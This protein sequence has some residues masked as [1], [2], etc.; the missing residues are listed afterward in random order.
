MLGGV[1]DSSPTQRLPVLPREAI[2][3]LGASRIRE[4]ANAAMGRADV[5]PF[6]FGESDVP[7]AG[8]IRTAGAESLAAGET[9]YTHNLGLPELRAAIAA[10][11]SR[12]HN[13]VLTPDRVAVVSSGISGL[14]LTAQMLLAPGDR[15]VIVTPIWPNVT[16][17]PRILGAEVIRVPLAVRG[18]R[19]ALDLDHLLAALTPGTRAIFL[20]SPNNPTGWTIDA[21]SLRLIFE[22]CR[23]LG[24]WVVTDDVYERLVYNGKAHAPSLLPLADPED[25]FVSVNSFSKAWS[26]TGWR[27][28]WIEAPAPFVEELGKVIEYNTSCAPKFVQAGAIAALSDN[29]GEGTVGDM[30]ERLATARELLFAGFARHPEI[31]APVPAGAMYAFFRVDGFAEDMALAR[32]LLEEVGLGLAPGSAFGPEGQGWLR[33]CFAAGPEKIA[34]GLARLDRFLANRPVQS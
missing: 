19:W 23:R 16:E 3:S 27:A 18:G 6:W 11:R 4:I 29:R 10:Y 34:D 5:V 12:L 32:R 14:M 20:N 33:W 7:T 8:F 31:E 17:L 22:H 2:L 30:R 15:V 9:F 1:L 13:A 26:M 24:I 28:G 25:R 21:E